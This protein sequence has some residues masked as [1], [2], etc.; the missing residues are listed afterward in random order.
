[1]YTLSYLCVD[2]VERLAAFHKQGQSV[3]ANKQQETPSQLDCYREHSS[4]KHTKNYK[5]MYMYQYV[6]TV[7]VKYLIWLVLS[8]PGGVIVMQWFTETDCWVMSLLFES[9]LE[10]CCHPEAKKRVQR[11]K[12]MFN[13]CMHICACLNALY[14]H[15]YY[16][17]RIT[18]SWYKSLHIYS[19]C[20]LILC[21]KSK[22]QFH[23]HKYIWIGIIRTYFSS[24]SVHRSCPTSSSTECSLP[25]LDQRVLAGHA[26]TLVVRSFTTL[27]K[28]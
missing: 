25:Q 23:V 17:I 20:T 5:P 22:W 21:L 2:P 18:G 7:N 15:N 3:A 1:M 8:F 12:C 6:I 27:Y 28:C 14:H 13:A 26:P 10:S 4:L 16:D 11:M 24:I 19:I 9:H